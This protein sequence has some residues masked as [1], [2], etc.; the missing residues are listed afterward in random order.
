MRCRPPAVIIRAAAGGGSTR[1][2]RTGYASATRAHWRRRADAAGGQCDCAKRTE[3]TGPTCSA[4]RKRQAAGEMRAILCLAPRSPRLT[5]RGLRAMTRAVVEERHEA[6]IRVCSRH[7]LTA[8]AQG[9][10][11]AL[12]RP[13][14]EQSTENQLP[15][16]LSQ[17]T[18]SL[19]L[20]VTAS[21]THQ[22]K[23]M[24]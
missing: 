17:N 10:W 24:Q 21:P 8:T 12:Q 9:T 15:K 3:P 1:H 5:P 19:P 18:A 16:K 7:L 20:S 4:R 22:S 23:S 13:Q 14:Q 6:G 11:E 2:P